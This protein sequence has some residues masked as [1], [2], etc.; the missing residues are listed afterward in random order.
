LRAKIAL[1]AARLLVALVARPGESRRRVIC[2]L[3]FSLSGGLVGNPTTPSCSPWKSLLHLRAVEMHAL[4]AWGE[5]TIGFVAPRSTGNNFDGNSSLSFEVVRIM[6]EHGMVHALLVAM[7]RVPLHHPLAPTTVGALMLPF[8]ILTRSSVADVVKPIVEKEVA[9]KEIKSATKL[10][11]QVGS[12][13][14]GQSY[15]HILEDAFC[16]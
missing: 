5:L 7:H 3:V 14:Q 4:K 10:A 12:A 8:E 1:S 6:L 11:K 16:S 15:D 13:D 9:S 2:E